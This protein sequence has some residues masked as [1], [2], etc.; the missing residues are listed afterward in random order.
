M[1]TDR[2]A[3]SIKHSLHA[4]QANSVQKTP[5]VEANKVQCE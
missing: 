4:R 3:L 1:W 2:Q 5:R